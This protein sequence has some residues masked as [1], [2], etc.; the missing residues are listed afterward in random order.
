MDIL[1]NLAETMAF[2]AM[3]EAE[4][5]LKDNN[6]PTPAGAPQISMFC[7]GTEHNPD[8]GEDYA[9]AK[10]FLFPYED[11]VMP[12]MAANKYIARLGLEDLNNTKV[13]DTALAVLRMAEGS[14]RRLGD[15]YQKD[16]PPDRLISAIYAAMELNRDI[17]FLGGDS[18]LFPGTTASWADTLRD[19]Y[20]NELKTK[21]DFRVYPTILKLNRDAIR[22]GA[23]DLIDD[24]ISAMTFE[25]DIDTKF[26]GKWVADKKTVATGD[27][28]QKGVVKNMKPYITKESLWG[29][30]NNLTLWAQSGT[31]TDVPSGAT[32]LKGLGD[33][34]SMWLKNW[35]ACV[36]KSFDVII[37][38][39]NGDGRSK[40]GKV[41]GPAATAAFAEFWWP[42]V[43][44]F[45]F[46]VPMTNLNPTLGERSI[47]RSG[48]GAD[49]GYTCTGVIRIVIKHTPQ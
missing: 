20:F 27:I 1:K 28:V 18:L 8:N 17:D 24:I 14:L 43:G 38:H 34:T 48:T 11:I 31:Y 40:S 29:D 21:H 46:S 12:L 7:R 19:Y 22:F 36:T 3:E 47:S 49:G 35:D 23:D 6:V 37:G 32:P 45:I 16:K 41:A 2:K 10:E 9:W 5:F 4:K 13:I 26:T 15:Q 42:K 25:V 33:T 30:I 44:G 39:F